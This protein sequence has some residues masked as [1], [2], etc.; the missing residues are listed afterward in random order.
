MAT[1]INQYGGRVNVAVSSGVAAGEIAVLGSAGLFGIALTDRYVAA[2][3]T[4]DYAL[5]PPQ[6]LSDGQAT[7]DIPGCAYVATFTADGT[8]LSAF[9][10]CYWDDGNNEITATSSSNT[11][12]GYTIEAIS[13]DA[14]GKVAVM[15]PGA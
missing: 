10:K 7:V 3:Y 15:A 13:A 8:G 9:V 12:I 4:S 2:T 11:F 5:T 14:T 6:G 1:N